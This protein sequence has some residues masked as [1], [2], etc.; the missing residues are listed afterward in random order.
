M[1][2]QS[3]KKWSSDFHYDMISGENPKMVSLHGHWWENDEATHDHNALDPL[4]C[5]VCRGR[6]S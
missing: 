1:E 4:G 5:N 6:G 3:K 2:Q